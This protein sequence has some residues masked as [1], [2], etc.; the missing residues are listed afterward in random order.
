MQ[1]QTNAAFLIEQKCKT[2]Q[3]MLDQVIAT[4]NKCKCV[5]FSWLKLRMLGNASLLMCANANDTTMGVQRYLLNANA[6]KYETAWL[7]MQNM[8]ILYFL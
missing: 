6:T 7:Q 5:G 2:M 3:I 4:V 8:Q 1:V